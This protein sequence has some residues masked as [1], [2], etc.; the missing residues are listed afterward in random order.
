[1]KKVLLCFLILLLIGCKDNKDNKEWQFN[2]SSDHP[3]GTFTASILSENKYAKFIYY[4]A[5][6]DPNIAKK[7]TTEAGYVVEIYNKEY[8]KA[9]CSAKKNQAI[10]IIDLTIGRRFS[11]LG[12]GDGKW[13][14]ETKDPV[15]TKIV[16]FIDYDDCFGSQDKI[17][18]YNFKK[19]GKS[20]ILDD[21]DMGLT[22]GSAYLVFLTPSGGFDDDSIYFLVGDFY[23]LV[24][25][26]RD[27]R[28]ESY[29]KNKKEVLSIWKDKKKK[30]EREKDKK[31][32]LQNYFEYNLKVLK[33]IIE[34]N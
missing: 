21:Y 17:K 25:D 7:N 30:K 31:E 4:H 22:S 33:N 16:F 13:L 8:I 1:M 19:S 28:S 5:K 12:K 29:A 18:L 23:N 32:K 24:L 14:R 27:N 6:Y 20:K 11:M 2:D 26:F 15:D 9:I 3:E 10:G 34:N